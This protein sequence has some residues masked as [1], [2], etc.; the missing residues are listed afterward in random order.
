MKRIFF[1]L[2]VLLAFLVGCSEDHPS[3]TKHLPQKTTALDDRILMDA[4]VS[5]ENFS[6]SRMQLEIPERFAK[7][8]IDSRLFSF[9]KDGFYVPMQYTNNTQGFL[10]AAT[11][12]KY[13]KQGVLT[14]EIPVPAETYHAKGISVL[15]DGRFV[16]YRDMSER[17]HTHQKSFLQIFDA[18]GLLLAECNVPPFSGAVEND[19]GQL[20]YQ[21]LLVDE[22]ADGTVRILINAVDRVFLYDEVL[23]LLAE[24]PIPGE[25]KRIFRES[26][27]VYI[28]GI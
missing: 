9:T 26:D 28:L 27:G 16:I 11:I 2:L 3:Y 1:L 24:Y 8:P 10:L 19:L 17:G 15:S 6:Y 18:E 4:V 5:A 14:D 21:S 7:E 12:L 25:C 13:D 23:T 20:D 22:A